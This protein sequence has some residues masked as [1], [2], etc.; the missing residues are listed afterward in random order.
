MTT[1]AINGIKYWGQ[2]LLLPI[3]WLSFLMP[4]NKNIWLFGSTFGRRFADNPRYLYLYVSQMVKKGSRIFDEKT[5][6]VTENPCY[7]DGKPIRPIWISHDRGIV[8]FLNKNEYEAYYYHSMR[9]I[10]FALCGKVFFYDNYSK[11]INFWQSGGAIKFNMWHGLPLK[12]IQHDNVFD[13]V[14]HPRNPWEV[15]KSLPRTLSDEKSSHYVLTT[16]EFMKPFFASAFRTDKVSTVG[17]PRIDG[18]IYGEINNLYTETES[19]ALY[20]IRSLLNR[21]IHGKMIYYMP[22]F[23]DSEKLFFEVMDL[24]KFDIYLREKEIV[25]S[26]KLHPKSKLRKEF[27]TIKSDNIVVIDA[28]TDPYVFIQM[29]DALITDYSSIYFDYLFVNK[30]IVFFAY[31]L[32][33][34]L[35]DSRELYFDYEKYTPGVKAVN[36]DELQKALEDIVEGKDEYGKKR[37]FLQAKMYDEVDRPI[38]GQLVEEMKN[39]I[40]RG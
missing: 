26:M 6:K 12:K 8:D 30:P 40:R 11:D 27:E 28:D 10:W 37:Q 9:G 4:R 38:S 34:Y 18:F 22:T 3:Y 21:C 32:K 7:I 14:R 20:N 17:Y 13:R 29:S 15:W 16:S 24:K 19:Q 23:R 2:L 25:F 36:Q 35:S 1:K 39:I 33:Q 5:G 31:D